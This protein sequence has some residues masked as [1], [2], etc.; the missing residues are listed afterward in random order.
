MP[1]QRILKPLL[2]GLPLNPLTKL[3]ENLGIQP[4]KTVLGN[5]PSQYTDQSVLIPKDIIHDYAP[6]IAARLVGTS[7]TIRRS[8]SASANRT[9]RPS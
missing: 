2:D 1:S 4:I 3:A 9:A 5:A 6:D 8:L 7:S